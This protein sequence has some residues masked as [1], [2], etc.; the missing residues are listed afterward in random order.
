MYFGPIIPRDVGK[1]GEGHCSRL[2]AL[3]GY[4][5]EVLSQ[6]SGHQ[7]FGMSIIQDCGECSGTENDT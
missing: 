7:H 4:S 6:L 1:H 3:S 5:V 2:H